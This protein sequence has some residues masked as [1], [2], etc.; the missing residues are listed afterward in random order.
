MTSRRWTV[1]QHVRAD[2]EDVFVPADELADAEV[3]DVVE[4][5]TGDVPSRTG[6]VRSLLDDATRGRFFI[7]ELDP[8]PA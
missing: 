3:G 4:F 5:V 1:D 6:R 7:V 2:A 8:P